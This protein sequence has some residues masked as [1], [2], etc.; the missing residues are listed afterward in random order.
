MTNTPQNL[1]GRQLREA[2][3]AAGLTQAQLAE[4]SGLTAGIVWS[5]ENGKAQN[6]VTL[7]RLLRATGHELRV[8]PATRL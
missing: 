1:F 2:R 7:D 6:A 4:K 3:K 5:T 8:A